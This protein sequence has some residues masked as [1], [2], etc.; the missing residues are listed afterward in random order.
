[1]GRTQSRYL[2]RT[3]RI[4]VTNDDGVRSP[5]LHALVDVAKEFGEVKFAAPDRERSACGHAM[6]LHEPLRAR[7]FPYGDIEGLE[8]NGVPVDCVN[9]GLDLLFP[10]GCDLI[11][12]GINN[13]PNL[14]FDI[15]YS[16]TVAGAMEGCLNGV[17]SVAVSMAGLV[18]GAPL[19]Y[20]TA[21]AW[22][23]ENLE[24]LASTPLPSRTFLNVNVP[25]VDEVSLR[26][27]KVV[28]MG[29]RIYEERIERRDDPW[30]RPYFWQGG[31]VV[32]DHTASDS[33]TDVGA[34]RDGFVAIT[35]LT[36]DWT[37][38]GVISGLSQDFAH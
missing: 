30:G 29:L 27:H 18:S 19:H 26:G 4:L 20:A 15:T 6:T 36:L 7:P 38:E 9:I 17:R 14:G 28:R 33:Q 25:N 32:V 3:V 2:L 31:A 37:A 21:Q 5:G 34:V 1:M 16:G 13:G 35:P 22:L 10:D 23:R 8:I 11:L 12:S 24:K